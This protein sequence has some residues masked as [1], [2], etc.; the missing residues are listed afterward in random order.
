MA[1]YRSI[2]DSTIQVEAVRYDATK[3]ALINIRA[4]ISV[5]GETNLAIVKKGRLYIKTREGSFVVSKGF[6]VV[7][8][9][10]GD[11]FVSSPLD[12]TSVYEAGT[13]VA[14]T[15]AESTGMGATIINVIGGS[16]QISGTL[17]VDYIYEYTTDHGVIIEGVEVMDD[18][19]HAPGEVLAYYSTGATGGEDEEFTSPLTTKGDLLTYTTDDVRFPVGTDGQVLSAD[20]GEATGLKWIDDVSP[21]TTKGDVFTYDTEN[22]RIAVGTDGQVLSAN[23]ATGTGLA[24]IDLPS[25]VSVGSATRIPYM[26]ATNDDF[27]YS[28]NLVFDSGTDTLTTP[29][30]DITTDLT[31]DTIDEHTGDAG[32]TID[33]VLIKD[34]NIEATGVGANIGLVV[35]QKGN[36]DLILGRSTGVSKVNA[37]SIYLTT[38]NVYLGYLTDCGIKGIS[39]NAGH[40]QG[41]TI[42]IR[43][44]AGYGVGDNDG[45]DIKIYGGAPNDAGGR[46]NIY[47]GDGS[48]NAYLIARTS[49]TNV[50][51][52]DDTTGLLSYDTV[53]GSYNPERIVRVAKS[54]GDYTTIQAA[55]NSITDA[56]VDKRYAVR[57]YPGNYAEAVTMKD[58]V[59]IIGTGRTNSRITGTTGTILTFP[60]TK[61]T[62]RDMGIYVDYGA[63]GADSTAITSAGDDSVMIR[64]DI[65][66]TKSSGDYTMHALA[67]TA[68]AFRMS[69]CYFTYSITGATTDTQLTQSAIVQGGVLTTFIMNNN[70][71]IIT[72]DDTN[73]DLVGFETTAEVTGTYLIANNVINVDA[74]ADGSSATGLWLYGTS[75]GGII[76][77]NRLTVNCNATAYGLWIDSYAGGAVIDSR[78][79]EIIITAVGAAQS[80]NVA[81]GDTWNSVFDKITAK[82]GYAGAGTITFASSEIDGSFG[83]T[84]TIEAN[85]IN[86]YTADA[87]VAIELT[88]L[89]DGDVIP[90]DDATYDLGTTDVRWNYLYAKNVKI[91][92]TTKIYC[93]NDNDFQF[94]HTGG[95]SYI[96]SIL[97]GAEIRIRGADAGSNT[98]T[99]IVADPDDSVE[100]YYA[101]A[102]K[103]ETATGGAIITGEL[104]VDNI[105]ISD[106]GWV[107]WGSSN[108]LGIRNTGGT[109]FI[110]STDHG[111]PLL[112]QGE[113]TGGALRTLI[114]ADPDNSV[115]LY[116]NGTQKIITTATGCTLSGIVAVTGDIA[117]TEGADHTS[118]P[119][120]GQ[121][122]LWVRN[123]VPNTLIFTNDAGTDMEIGAA[124]YT[125][126]NG[127]T[128]AAGVA[129]LGGALTDTVE[130]TTGGTYDL[131]L[132]VNSPGNYWNSGF[133]VSGDGYSHMIFENS[134]TQHSSFNVQ[135][136]GPTIRQEDDSDNVNIF[137]MLSGIFEVTDAQNSKGIVYAAD[138][139]ANWT[140][141]SLVTKKWVTDNFVG[142]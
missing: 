115:G 63:L 116:H 26:N 108:E 59:D 122:Y 40:N 83:V 84:G 82:S 4:L 27:D 137:S 86:E 58:Y 25:T 85:T 61:A 97:D 136:Y 46:G 101:G 65:G 6:Y 41:A 9:S 56:A 49:E 140:D 132:Y 75:T 111:A 47:F 62:I 18:H 129:E 77:Q 39:G 138:Y 54:G 92:D 120:A 73:D 28:A 127:L 142:V 66:V 95:H 53:S 67:I 50:V 139:S 38:D 37:S 91:P 17:Y 42:E 8:D 71:L 10:Y 23:S 57:V 35:R 30:I 117:I 1:F 60:A 89:K 135:Q 119:Q 114:L 79:N 34:Y 44:G 134:A 131:I 32:I 104:A 109:N 21:L 90:G 19:V 45:G 31:V 16:E 11:I 102:K 33:G 124:S 68:G 103:F 105:A 5:A 112:I 43:G 2:K 87:G 125:F 64:C 96:D 7:K 52:Y 123:D 48:A 88:I 128:E 51:Y 29:N 118:T 78:H 14:S 141:H 72:S 113:D 15:G 74:G 3:I 81:T 24:W 133:R 36:A 76:I 69:D 110:T 99:M 126:E 13:A 80:A 130:I 107:Y 94:Y 121:G 98:R 93:G 70:E 20:S 12:F 106:D 22:T 55:I 100:L